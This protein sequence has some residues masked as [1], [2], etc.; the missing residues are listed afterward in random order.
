M[1]ANASAKRLFHFELDE[2]RDERHAVADLIK[3]ERL[4]N[5][6]DDARRRRGT[7]G[8]NEELELVDSTGQAHWFNVTATHLAATPGAPSNDQGVVAVLRNISAEKAVQKR[9]AEFVSSVSHE[10][11]T[12]LAGIKAYVEL[13]VDGDAED[14]ETREEFLQVINGQ[15]DSLQRLIDNLLNLARIEAGVVKVDRQH[16]SLNE[17]LEEAFHIVQPAAE[18]KNITLQSALSPMYLGVLADRDLLLQA[19]INLL[20]N[21]IKYTPDGGHVTLRSRMTD[22]EVVVEVED[23]GV[24]LSEEDCRR[25][26]ERFYRVK[27]DSDMAPGTG[28]GLALV[29]H[30]VQDVHNGQVRVTSQL[31]VGSTFSLT[32]PSVAQLS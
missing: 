24:G 22:G 14:E 1:L 27:K 19:V 31:G 29:Q 2:T 21:A 18:R 10:M 13:L 6:I 15:A 20:S 32:L 16:R 25:V 28:L 17:I 11:K 26:F 9:N 7:N 30:I 5:L 8:R 3:C 12:P 4:L 23:S